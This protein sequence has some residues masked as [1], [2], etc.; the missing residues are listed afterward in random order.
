MSTRERLAAAA[1]MVLIWAL[2][3][4]LFGA[5]F[6]GLYRVC[7]SAALAGW[8]VLLIATAIAGAITCAFYSAM[9]I[10]L[11]GAMAGV[12]TSIGYVLTAGAEVRLDLMIVLAGVLGLMVGRGYAGMV[13]ADSHPLFHTLTGLVAGCLAGTALV[14]LFAVSGAQ[15]ALWQ[16]V[17]LAVVSVGLSFEFIEWRMARLIRRGRSQPLG[18]AV[19]AALTATAVA[20]SIWF[21]G[22]ATD[23]FLEPGSGSA[24]SQALD[25]IPNG[26]VGGLIG[27]AVSGL[28]LEGLGVRVEG[29]LS[30]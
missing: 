11:A 3:G 22:G 26:L 14:L 23:A 25:D 6:A 19:V 2:A 13:R 7:W 17:A 20:A 12:L 24:L 8:L 29:D 18:A 1:M 9:P 4:A 10:A 28:F 27:G 5:L 21:I 30:A 15:V 16:L